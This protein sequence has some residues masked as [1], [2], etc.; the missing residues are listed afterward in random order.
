MVETLTSTA[1]PLE[2]TVAPQPS[3]FSRYR[4]WRL[5]VKR[6]CDRGVAAG[7]L[8]LLAPLLLLIGVAVRVTSP[9]PSLFRQYRVGRGGELF[10]IYKFRTMRRDAEAWLAAQPELA[11]R[12][13]DNDFKLAIDDDVRVTPLGRFLRR[14]SLDEL[15]QLVN[16]LR[17]EMSL[18]GPRPV[19]PEE[20]ACYEQYLPS[21][22]AAY[23][24][25]TGLWQVSGH[26]AVGYPERARLDADY[27]ESWSLR[28]DLSIAVR[29]VPEMVRSR[30]TP[31]QTLIDLRAAPSVSLVVSTIG[32]PAELARLLASVEREAEL[33]Q[34]EVIVVDQSDDAATA[35][36]VDRF[37]ERL[38]I[39]HVP[40]ERTGV[41]LG[42]NRGLAE[43]RGRYVM[44]PDDDAWL[45]GA[46]LQRAVTF[47]E[48]N[49]DVDGYSARLADER[50]ANSM[51][52]WRRRA[53]WVTRRNHHRTSI[54]SAI[55]V[56]RSAAHRVAGFDEQ[57]GP[58][59]GT[60]YGSCEDAD[61]LLKIVGRGRVWYE[62]LAVVHHRDDRSDEGDHAVA[63]AFAYGCGQ[64]RLWRRHL[65]LRWAL[66]LLARR[67]GSSVVADLRESPGVGR[68]RRAWVRGAANGLL[69]RPPL[70]IEMDGRRAAP[71]PA[72]ASAPTTGEFDTSFRWRLLLSAAGI[73]ASFS[74]T[75]FAARTFGAAELSAFYVVLSA[76]A[77]G[78]VLGR[79]GYGTH[80]VQRL[81]ELRATADFD[82]AVA[83]GRAAVRSTLL[84]SVGGAVV[85]SSV[86]LGT[87][88]G[89][90]SALVLACVAV[91]VA[92]ES[93]RMTYSDVFLG[94]GLPRWSAGLAH[95]LRA[96]AVVAWVGVLAAAGVAFDLLTVLAVMVGCGL[97]L[98]AVGAVRLAALQ[99]ERGV[100]TAHEQP[101]WALVAIGV[102]FMIVDL[103]ALTIAR[104]DV[105]ISSLVFAENDASLYGTASIVAMQLAIPVGLA[106]VALAPVAA[107]YLSQRRTTELERLVR[108]LVT[109]LTMFAAASL[110]IVVL[111]GSIGL[112]VAFGERFAD[113][114]LELIILTIGNLGLVVFGMSPVVLVM[115]GRQRLAMRLSA[116]WL[117]FALPSMV[118]A[119][120]LAG[121]VGLAIASAIATIGL[122]IVLAAATWVTTGVVV[123]PYLWTRRRRGVRRRAVV[124]R[125]VRRST[126]ARA[127]RSVWWL[128]PA[129]PLVLVTIP[130][131]VLSAV[132]D[133]ATFVSA[134]RTPKAMDL[135]AF[136]TLLAG[137]LVLLAGL[138]IRAL[139]RPTPA[140]APPSRFV[141]SIPTHRLEAAF[142]LLVAATML[143]Y[144]AWVTNGVLNAGLRLSDLVDL[145][146]TQDNSGLELKAK[147]PTIA[148][149][150]TLTQLGIAAVIIGVVIDLRRPTRWVRV[151]YRLV[152]ALAL[153]RSFV[154]AER[155][156]AIELLVP[157]VTLRVVAAFIRGDR[158]Q[159]LGVALAPAFAAVLLV[160]TFV[161]SEAS[162]SWNFYRDQGEQSLVAFGTERLLG[163]YVTAHNNGAILLE[164]DTPSTGVPFET[165]A[166]FWEAPLSPFGPGTPV[167]FDGPAV[168]AEAV[169]HRSEAL[170]RAGNPEFNSPS[171]LAAPFVDFG[172]VGGLAFLVAAGLVI[173]ALHAG[174][175][176]GTSWGVFFYP[177]VFVGLLE[178]P[179]YQYWAQGRSTPALLALALVAV[180]GSRLDRLT[181]TPPLVADVPYFAD[182]GRRLSE[183]AT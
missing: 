157:L 15:P 10:V 31:R 32:R 5:G 22:Y 2:A 109:G 98:V 3:A 30:R 100:Q 16:V 84:P 162:R 47:L 39:R 7:L 68:V 50:G 140:Q 70:D 152:I 110:A 176:Q 76:L 99:A 113:A 158:E 90:R 122:V 85:L 52:R 64:G 23:P 61:F 167:P 41:S 148:G 4:G 37:R 74:L 82:I 26:E 168:V 131:L 183:E 65:P 180:V 130:T 127:P 97:L 133:E 28:R 56:R 78:P 145:L 83:A 141:A 45:S 95:Q 89:G 135:P 132:I 138:S 123:T 25:L 103:V 13:R 19:V 6:V 117:G 177:V 151:A 120:L 112:R 169:D 72:R 49:F 105:W 1:T 69:A 80:I 54:G 42:R 146:V 116:A 38:L 175:L 62:P 182:W 20:A 174:L 106:N 170:G 178:L 149:V 91:V 77:I 136:T 126:V 71:A 12:H 92:A 29:T 14:T 128:W 75:V 55:V 119:A 86:L 147:L 181:A 137:A 46:T 161:G 33:V 150:T 172:V 165:I 101:L 43:A 66:F 81:G 156:A 163:Y 121:R 93:V 173:G 59:A 44:F 142:Q 35:D 57:M 111:A 58:G 155:L 88:P 94:L 67:L 153:V 134:W 171:G 51:L 164:E 24:G 139:V 87:V 104:G 27:V 125:S 143:G 9:G 11:Q 124:S 96:V 114:Q 107:G 179:R 102:P 17:G 79:F 48:A 40:C 166:F 36:V 60:W 34:L 73:T 53:Q 129:A 21:Y 160:T 108:R 63:K 118:V 154:L 115:A 8:L 144:G 18:V 159:R